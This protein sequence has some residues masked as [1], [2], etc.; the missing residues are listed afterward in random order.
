MKVTLSAATVKPYI[1]KKLN[2]LKELTEIMNEELQQADEIY[3]QKLSK[4]ERKHPLV[5]F[6]ISKPEHPDKGFISGYTIVKIRKEDI[7]K[8]MEHISCLLSSLE[9][10]TK[11]ELDE[12][13]VSYYEI[14]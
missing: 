7:E 2:Y 4:Y 6:F 5:K 8:R 11:V 14:V 10:A 13:D 9:Y 3:K 12:K 1:I